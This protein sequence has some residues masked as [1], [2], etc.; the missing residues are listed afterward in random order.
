M[1]PQNSILV[2]SQPY[3]EITR[4]VAALQLGFRGEH[5]SLMAGRK[6]YQ[7]L[8]SL[9]DHR[10]N[11]RQTVFDEAPMQT[12]PP[13]PLEILYRDADIVAI[14][15]PAGLLSHR[16]RVDVLAT[17]FAVEKLS[18]QIN[19]KVF[20]IHRL[21]RPTSG[22]LLFALD[23]ATAKALADQF[24]QRT[25]EKQYRAIVR[26]FTPDQ[27]HID[28]PLSRYQDSLTNES[29]ANAESQSAVTE[30]AT[31][32]RWEI[33]FSAGKYPNSRYSEVIIKPHT[34]RR[35]QI[36]RH[37]NHLAH[38]IIGDSSHGDTRHNRMFREQ[39]NVDRLLLVAEVLNFQ[40]PTSNQTI[41]IIAPQGTEFEHAVS[42]LDRF[43]RKVK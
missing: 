15:K 19:A 12:E 3:L 43:N 35:H 33:P 9:S 34:G 2:Q 31:I 4:A 1:R 26:G 32:R 24:A 38:P 21:D 36:R 23:A 37:F 5:D 39:L 29:I 18:Q 42:Q 11:R 17:E 8:G 7:P 20:L 22:V 40:H 41:E 14:N 27:G 25:I 28:E 16:N 10:Y 30:F 13:L 6:I